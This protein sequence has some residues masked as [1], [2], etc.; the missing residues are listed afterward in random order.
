MFNPQNYFWNP[1][2][3]PVFL[4]GVIFVFLGL[5]VGLKNRTRLNISF[6]IWLIFASF[7]LFGNSLAYMSKYDWM[8]IEIY[9]KFEFLGV[10]FI[11]IA[12][13]WVS[14]CW[15]ATLFKKQKKYITIG[16]IISSI[17]YLTNLKYNYI[18]S[19]V[20]HYF[21]GRYFKNGI[22]G[23][24]FIIYWIIPLILTLVNYINLY[25]KATGMRKR[26]YKLFLIA[27]FIVYLGAT[28]WLPC[29][30]L[31]IYPFG[32]IPVLVFSFL[33]SYAIIHY[34]FMNIR[35]VSTR[36]G[37]FLAVYTVVLG[38]PFIVLHRTGSGLLATSLAVVFASAG[39]IL[40]RFLQ[41]KAEAIVLAKQLNYQRILL[42][43]A[44]TMIV[45]HD[46]LKLSRLIVYILKKTIKLKFSAIFV[47]NKGQTTYLLKAMRGAISAQVRDAILNQEHPFI[48]YLKENKEPFLSEE[49]PLQIKD[50]LN[51]PLELR[52][53]IP[54]FAGDELLAFV[55]LG[56][57]VNAE[58][59]TQ[60]DINVF[61]ILAR[62]A[63]LAIQNCE[64]FEESKDYQQRM[65]SAEKLASIGGMA[66]GIAHQIKNRL[67]LFSLAGGELKNEIKSFVAK[68]DKLIN[69]NPELD[70]TFKYLNEIAASIIDNVKRTD[71]VI[72]GI[73]DFAKVDNKEN[74]FTAFSFK[75]IVELSSRLLMIKHEVD[76]LPISV[77]IDTKDSL[78]AAKSQL[79]EV[80]YNLMDNAYE[81]IKEKE[82]RISEKELESFFPII[83]FSLTYTQDRQIIKILDNGIGIKEE[84]K[85]KI[86]APFFT[87]KASYKSGSG[88]GAYVLKRIIEEN[89]KGKI[90]F[91][92]T[93][94]KGTS[95]I[96]ELPKKQ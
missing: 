25:K 66:D 51:L 28:D 27:T 79:T 5:F 7:W 92:S 77:K 72:K 41:R 87:T 49:M 15:D 32:F 70:K 84:D 13:Y 37:I 6:S 53:V 19:G 90:W 85:P 83:Q 24:I 36:A 35:I 30:G 34:Q 33:M 1:H 50:S 54:A 88:I 89:H 61:K 73:L 18:L 45:E 10:C 81:A 16:F 42:Q 62:Q 21:W 55:L 75:G 8:V 60:E 67:N 26:Q 68:H 86:F 80:I 9:N 20:Y 59:Y 17:F 14:L 12:S 47:K 39:P 56:D 74:L 69:T 31:E 48:S 22:G 44:T 64:F 96:I 71:G 46:L 82:A 23:T 58:P 91:T 43:A 38:I 94:M 95:F 57:K 76:S 63:T 52:T 29:Y 11:S 4:S 40:Y 2:V 3:V 93:Y 65:F 78:Y